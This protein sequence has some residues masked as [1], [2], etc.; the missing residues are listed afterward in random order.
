MNK[1]SREV[2]KRITAKYFHQD[3]KDRAKIWAI[4]VL[5]RNSLQFSLTKIIP[6]ILLKTGAT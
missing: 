5:S 3:D 1:N 2:R 6:V 4:K